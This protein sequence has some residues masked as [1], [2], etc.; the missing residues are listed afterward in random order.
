M[1]VPLAA[2]IMSMVSNPWFWGSIMAYM[3]LSKTADITTGQLIHGKQM[4][5]E[6]KKLAAMIKA[7]TSKQEVEKRMYGEMKGE[8]DEQRDYLASMR[9]GDRS[10]EEEMMVLKDMLGSDDKNRAMMMAMMGNNRPRER[11]YP[12]VPIPYAQLTQL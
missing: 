9:E 3:G 6:E 11:Q 2:P 1:V 4:G 7:M 10:H 5:L 8:R 12:Q